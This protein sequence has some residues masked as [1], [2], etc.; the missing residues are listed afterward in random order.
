MSHINGFPNLTP[1]EAAE[2]IPDGAT[3]AFSGFANAGTAKAIPRALAARA[4]M[5]HEAGTPFRIRVLTGGACS[6][7]VDEP[8]A[9][10]EA[11]SWRAAYQS[12]P[13]LRRQINQQNVE[14]LDMHLS[15]VGRTVLVGFF[16]KLDVAVIEAT[17][18]TP[19][20]RVYLSTSIGASPTFLRYADRVLIELNRAHSR[21]LPEMHDIFI[22][23]PPPRRQPIPI[24]ETM[25][26][27]GFP[28]AQVDPAKVIGIV[29]TDE[30]DQVPDRGGP[31]PANRKIAE[32]VVR[33]LLDEMEVGRIP[34]E[35]LPLQVGTGKTANGM[36]EAL[37]NHPDIPP[38]RMYTLAIRDWFIQLMEQGKLQGASASS[39]SLSQAVLKNV[40]ENMDFFVP[41]IVLRPQEIS[42]DPGVVRRLGVIAV[43][44]AIEVDIYGNA[45]ASHV[46]GTDMVNGIGGN[47]EFTRNSFLSFIVCPSVARGGRISNVVPMIPH[48]DDNEH[49]VQIIVTDQGLADLRGLGPMQRARAIIE[50]CAHPAYR[51]YLYRYIEKSRPG[52]IRHDLDTCFE[53][54]LNLMEHGAMLPDLDLSTIGEL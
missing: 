14:Y 16:G 43:N 12:A 19:D 2:K 18:V 38:F 24:H 4:R 35:F 23:D 51:D 10:S 40:Y 46:F 1:K 39:L 47:G 45:N 5:L 22:M 49:S 31:S 50:N 37:G 34:R 15:R 52:H 33:F 32:H 11:I 48:I 25:M 27:M 17:D 29:E 30:P 54:H 44:S 36:M 20:G 28:Y 3:V 13:A 7:T 8:L 42:N 6:E 9:G 26:R 41:R 53:L 21:R